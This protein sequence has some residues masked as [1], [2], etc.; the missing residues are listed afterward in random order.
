[1]LSAFE[2]MLSISYHAVLYCA[3]STKE[4]S[5]LPSALMATDCQHDDLL[6]LRVWIDRWRGVD[7]Y[8]GAGNLRTYKHRCF[9]MQHD[10]RRWNRCTLTSVTMVWFPLRPIRVIRKNHWHADRQSH[11]T[12]WHACWEGHKANKHIWYKRALFV[13]NGRRSKKHFHR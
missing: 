2:R 11:L 9:I 8:L 4:V 7:E 12:G 13:S 5:R 6:H 1:M 10:H 3:N